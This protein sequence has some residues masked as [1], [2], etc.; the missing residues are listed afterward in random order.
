M[1]NDITAS[2]S[3]E[4]PVGVTSS[5][6]IARTSQSNSQKIASRLLRT[7]QAAAY[8]GISAWKLRQLVTDRRLPVVQDADSGPFRLDVRDLDNYIESSKRR[9]PD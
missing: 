1:K 8:L 3:K 7:R 2:N 5:A 6:L 4:K 9:I